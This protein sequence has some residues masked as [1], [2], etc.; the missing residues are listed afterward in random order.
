MD[1]RFI[2]VF[3]SLAL[4]IL[5]ASF[6]LRHVVTRKNE[7]LAGKANSGNAGVLYKKGD[8]LYSKG[9]YDGAVRFLEVLVRKYPDSRFTE[10]A[11]LKLVESYKAK[12]NYPKA[13]DS[14]KEFAR[15]FPDSRARKGIEK[16]IEDLN[17]KSLFS[18]IKTK[19]SISYK[20]KPGDTLA[21]IASRFNTTV[22]LL[23][24]ANGLKS[25]LIL[26]GKY[27]KVN[28]AKFVI[29]VDKSKNVLVLK[30][31]DGEIIKTYRVSTGE[32]LNTP[33]GTFNI[34]E[35][36][37]SPS[38]Y[39]IGAVVEPDSPKYELGSRWMG[40]SI[41]GYGIHGTKDP[42]TI[43]KHITKGCIRMRN[44]EVEEL[45]AIVPSGTKVVIVD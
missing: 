27:L 33:T 16:K 10:K 35:K 18:N 1:R 19:D 11:L 32:N 39:K 24:R 44:R 22:E 7:K 21:R 26:P 31:L 28:R 37:I 45:Y 38:W 36:L 8:A 4:I 34:E 6:G 23:K 14:L 30:K 25:D 3:V 17:I 15:R 29:E 41:T 42:S 5:L 9:D 13:S 12:G 43:G 40:L 20:I 2:T